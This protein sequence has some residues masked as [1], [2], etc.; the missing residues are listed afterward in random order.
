M[1]TTSLDDL[2]GAR[3]DICIVGAGPVGISLALELSRLGRAILLVESS[4]T[5]VSDDVQRLATAK[6]D[7]PQHHV[8]MDVA[9]Q[10]R[11]GGASNLW[12][13]RC[14]AMEPID[15]TPRS[16]V[17]GSGWPINTADVSPYMRA[18]CDYLGCGEPVFQDPLSGLTTKDMAFE[19]DRLER[20]SARPRIAKVFLRGCATNQR[21]IYVCGPPLSAET[22]SRIEEFAVSSS[23]IRRARRSLSH[24]AVWC[25]QQEVWKIPVCYWPCNANGP[26]VLAA[27]MARLG[28]TTWEI[29]MAPLRRW[30][31]ILR[32][33]TRAWITT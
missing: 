25:W 15:F 4:G 10:R 21:L 2:R 14:V 7:N 20:W 3:C 18:A 30:S 24:R 29:F 27:R 6:I 22:K 1:I 23:A 11:L 26:I 31:F 17:P 32:P 5:R 8:S 28:G 13:V 33:L 9:V 16:G 12:G 19:F